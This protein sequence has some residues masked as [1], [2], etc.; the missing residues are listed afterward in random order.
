MRNSGTILFIGFFLAFGL[1]LFPVRALAAN[2]QLDAVGALELAIINLADPFKSKIKVV[3]EPV[4]VKPAVK[5]EAP[6]PPVKKDPPKVE[7]K[8]VLPPVI[9]L[10]AMSLTG[11]MFSKVRPMA[12]INGEV[13][14]PGDSLAA[15]NGVVKLIEIKR[16]SVLVTYSGKTFTIATSQEE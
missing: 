13:V 12:I 6:P 7:I 3:V 10:P 11:I 4:I 15:G 5:P 1:G 16:D 9:T 2:A 14:E 8:P